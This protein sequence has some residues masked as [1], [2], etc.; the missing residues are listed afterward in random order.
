MNR[1]LDAFAHLCILC[2]TS[3]AAHA[4]VSFDRITQ[5]DQQPQNW[6]TYSRDYTG[7][8]FSPF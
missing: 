3:A 1:C 6:M 5:A 4:D 7:Q 2:V 8:R